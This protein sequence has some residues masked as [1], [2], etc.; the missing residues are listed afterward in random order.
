MRGTIRTTLLTVLFIAPLL[1]YQV[2]AQQ[3]IVPPYIQPGNAPYLAKEQKTII[4][5]TDSIAGKYKVE[6]ALGT[7]D[8]KVSV[9]KTSLVKLNLNNKT[10]F[11]YR[12][13]L[14]GLKFDSH[15]SYRVSL[16]EKPIAEG[17]FDSRTKKSQ[18]RFA[19]FGDCGVGSTQQA[20]IA[21]QVFQQKPQFVLVTGDNVYSSGLESEYR[22]RF[23]PQY[24]AA[25][26]NPERG[27]PIMQTIPFYML[28][29][30]HDIYGAD[31]DKYPDGLA[32]FYYND[33]P[34]NGP[35]TNALKATGIEERVKKFKA[36]SSPRFPRM[37]NFSFDYGNVHIACID[38]NSYANP[39]DPALVQW[40]SDDIKRSRADWKIVAYHHPG[41]NSSK[42][43]YDYQQM[44]LLAPVLEQLG[45]DMVLTGHVHNYQRT[46]PLKFDPKKDSTGTRYV[47]SE[48]GRVDGKFTLDEKYDGKT[49]TKPNGIIYIVTGAGG[50]PLYDPALSGKPDLWKH[51]P[52]E[53]WVPFTAKI[54]SDIH[55]FTIIET[56]GKNLVLKQMDAKGVV[57]DEIVVTK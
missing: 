44:R 52:Q 21:Y 7:L 17:S 22:K 43:H 1:G 47:V 9:A 56:N 27:A 46:M 36:N 6:F 10:T 13:T 54:V 23:F 35:I 31:L 5:Q 3:I 33:L 45:V 48:Q 12:A 29:G 38:A 40:L 57:F 42:A 39:L 18:T 14:T 11:L 49:I 28:V 20:E 15:Y 50:A 19:V 37:S 53:N 24:T 26:A 51:D 55:S 2:S 30:N 32:Y 25:K 34:L 8:G 41:F 16:N 4:W